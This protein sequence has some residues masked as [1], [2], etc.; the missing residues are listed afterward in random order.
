MVSSGMTNC[1]RAERRR[2]R[3]LAVIPLLFGILILSAGAV[4]RRHIDP[5]QSFYVVTHYFSDYLADSYE[6]ILDVTPEG[7]DVRVR[8]IRISAATRYCGGN[9]VRAAERLLPDA[10]PAKVARGVDLCSYSANGVALALKSATPKKITSIEDSATLSYVAK[11]GAEEKVFE[12]P[13][14]ETFDVKILDRENPHVLALWYLNYKIRKRT[15][16]PRSPIPD[17]PE[18]QKELEDLGTM[19]LPELVSGKYEAGFDGAACSVPECD[20]NYLAGLLSGY[21]G[22][23]ANRDPAS[24]ELVNASSLHLA[25]YDLPLFPRIAEIAHVFGEVHLR[26]VSDPQTGLVKEVELLSGPRLLGEPAVKAA[27]RWQFS[28]G[29]Q[30]AQPVEA[31]LKF[32]LCPDH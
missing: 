20:T 30:S 23:P 9:L 14:P 4:P 29:T 22:P 21:T 1:K 13:Y 3:T 16:G 25:T 27:K 26:I 10:T 12:F 2:N 8:A 19:L 7:K 31:I 17:L 32:S 5:L 6:E 18:A 24:V 15:F 28:P 11:C